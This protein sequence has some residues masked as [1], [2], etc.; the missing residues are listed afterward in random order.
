M[1]W[2]TDLGPSA[3]QVHHRLRG[4]ALCDRRPCIT[5]SPE[6]LV[7]QVEETPATAREPTW[8]GSGG[9]AL[10]LIPGTSLTPDQHDLA[11][12]LM[13]GHHPRTGRL[14]PAAARR[15]RGL[16]LTVTQP[17]SLS[18]LYALAEQD[19]AA[20]IEAL[21]A[22]AV[23]EAAAQL[24]QW[25][26]P[27]SRHAGLLGWILW[28]RTAPAAGSGVPRPCLHAHLVIATLMRDG[29]GR[30]T[31]MSR[32][33]RRA[34]HEHAGVM[35]LYARARVRQLLSAQQQVRWERDALTGVWEVAGIAPALRTLFA[36]PSSPRTQRGPDSTARPSRRGAKVPLA[37]LAQRA[38]PVAAG[39][40]DGHSR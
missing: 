31:D 18:A 3:V 6:P 30:W 38:K 4:G 40:G 33:R 1:V 25:I 39:I 9:Q 23:G 34:L 17:A 29:G 2:I 32:H 26:T 20:A 28:H 36:H 12:A 19:Q 16:E 8:F 14:R 5:G 35:E 37:A 24:E 13:S 27:A 15:S 11:S 10:G 7:P 21:V 22:Q